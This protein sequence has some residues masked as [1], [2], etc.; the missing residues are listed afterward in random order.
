MSL[1]AETSTFQK[2]TLPFPLILQVKVLLYGKLE[3]PAFRVLPQNAKHGIL[4]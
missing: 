1:P 2:K 4:S 3:A